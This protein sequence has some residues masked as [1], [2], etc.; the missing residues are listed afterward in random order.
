MKKVIEK[1]SNRSVWVMY[2]KYF[3]NHTWLT[4]CPHK[5]LEE[6][7]LDR[8]DNEKETIDEFNFELVEVE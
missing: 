7:N 2:H 3:P 8:V 6:S 4:K 1:I 5:W